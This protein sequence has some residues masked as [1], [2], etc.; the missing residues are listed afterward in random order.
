[1]KIQTLPQASP[2]TQDVWQLREDVLRKP[3]GLSLKT[4][5]LSG[6]DN[7][8]VLAAT[9]DEKVIG[10]LLLRLLPNGKAKLRQ[11]AVRPDWQKKGV[12]KAL[13]DAAEEIA[14][15][16]EALFLELNARETAVAF[17]EAAGYHPSGEPFTEVG[18]PHI[19]MVKS[20]AQ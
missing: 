18:I 14:L 2:L 12:G 1:M 19:K 10:C 6:E 16:N 15:Q 17:Y 20:L 8:L 5:D 11:M 7:D 13:L 3:I 4:E 9:E